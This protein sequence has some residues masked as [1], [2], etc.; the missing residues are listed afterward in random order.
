MSVNLPVSFCPNSWTESCRKFVFSKHVPHDQCDQCD[1]CDQC[2]QYDLYDQCDQ[3]DHCDQC[4]YVK[5]RSFRLDKAQ[6]RNV[7]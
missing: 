2:D 5:I 6:T 7:P 3:C 1:L 4:C